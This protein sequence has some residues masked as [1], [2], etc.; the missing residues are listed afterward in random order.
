MADSTISGLT[1]AGSAQID[2]E[3]PVNAI[4]VG[5]NRKVTGEQIRTFVTDHL[6][7]RINGN[8]G[9]AGSY[10]TLQKLSANATANA[11][12]TLQTVMTTTGVAS[13]TYRF[14]YAVIYQAAAATTGVDFAIGHSGTATVVVSSWFP[15][16]GGTAANG[17]ADQVGSNT[18]SL[19]EGKGARALSTKFGSSLGVDT[20][21]ANCLM[22]IEGVLVVT[23]SGSLT[24]QHCSEVAASS[25]VMANTCL[26]LTRI[27]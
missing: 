9:A 15:T 2:D 19:V 27:G 10:T 26:E 8:S 16:S 11:T 4:S 7:L 23:V 24:L 18:A 20:L 12:T 21:N 3:Y 13:G 6:V 25:Q 1:A 14:T 22:M 17:L 5:D